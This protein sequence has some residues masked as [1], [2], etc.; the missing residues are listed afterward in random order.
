M[1]FTVGIISRNL[2]TQSNFIRFRDSRNFTY[3][4]ARVSNDIWNGATLRDHVDATW[5]A[6][7]SAH[8]MRDM[9]DNCHLMHVSM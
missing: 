9:C 7:R 2:V 4:E 1:D 3:F 8:G 5:K 6:W